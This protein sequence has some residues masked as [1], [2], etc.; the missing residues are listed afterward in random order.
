MKKFMI[1]FILLSLCV[2]TMGQGDQPMLKKVTTELSRAGENNALTKVFLKTDKDRYAP[3]E[4][5]W[6]KAEAF[7]CITQAPS[8]EAELI[9]MLKGESGQVIA[10]NRYILSNGT[11]SD[12]LILPRWAPEGDAYLVVC[13]AQAF[14][15][16]DASLSAVKPIT[17]HAWKKNEFLPEL[18]LSRKL[19]RP[20]DEAK[21]SIRQLALSSGNIREKWYV[22]L[23]DYHQP[24]FSEKLS[25]QDNQEFK[26]KIPE[27]ISNGLYLDVRNQGKTKWVRKIPLYTY[28]DPLTLEFFAEGGALLTN[29][30]QRILYR[31]TDPFGNP[32]EISGKV[33]DANK[34]H[35]GVGK[36]LKNGYGIINLMPL[37]N[38]RYVFVIDSD[39]GKGQEFELPEA[40]IDG[41]VF[42]LQKTEDSTLRVLLTANGKYIG[43][44]IT[45][46]AFH[47]GTLAMAYDLDVKD[48]TN[49]KIAT[50]ELPGGLILFAIIHPTDGILSERLVYNSPNRDINFDLSTRFSPTDHNGDLEVSVDLSNFIGQFGPSRADI[51]VVDRFNLYE[52]D[53]SL[54]LSFLKYPLL[55]PVPKTVLDLYLTN[56][57]LIANEF[58]HYRLSDL[59]KGEELPKIK[60]GNVISGSVVDKNRKAV[61]YATVMA[62]QAGD[63]TLAT[64]TADAKGRFVFEKVS[65]STDLS[66]KAFNASGK[67]SYTVHLDRTFDESLEEIL[68]MQSFKSHDMDGTDDFADYYRQNKDLLKKAG[69]EN[70]A[71]KAPKP[72]GTERML[73]SGSSILDVIRMTKPFRVESNQI[74]FY[75]SNNSLLYQSGA[76]IVID[77]QKMGTDM[78]VLNA[79]NPLDVKSVNISTNAVDIQRYTGLNSVGIIEINTRQKPEDFLSDNEEPTQTLG[80]VFDPAAFSPDVRKRQT[81]LFWGTDL[82]PDDEGKIGLKLKVGEL[83][84]E[85]VIQVE[86]ISENGVRHQQTSTFSTQNP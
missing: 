61:P 18:A 28:N 27:K 72:S 20:G 17:V 57:E 37:P 46:A 1:G 12:A 50:H 77:G 44:R 3:G 4:T 38:Q 34:N 22:S 11:C 74:V 7:H 49:L 25:V 65:K 31:A 73:Q 40:V 76:L 51:R 19:Y 60:P 24:I 80:S 8:P 52:P 48:K 35:V 2:Y 32:A 42:S 81:T 63:L 39:Y 79:I 47:N 59:M 84:T 13:T 10:D 30:L 56:L 64:T 69:T 23:Y 70:T 26:F 85:Y 9:V 66:V 62:L 83:K 68:L 33:F 82:Y 21:L 36:A 78:S 5:I 54:T 43:E 53:E 55:T 15:T 86:G 67:K 6:F 45:L 41:C 14:R 29:N 75:G 58:R 16:N 71:P